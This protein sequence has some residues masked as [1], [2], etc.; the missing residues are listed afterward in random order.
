MEEVDIDSVLD[1]PN[2]ADKLSVQQMNRWDYVE[3]E[4]KFSVPSHLRGSNTAGKESLDTLRGR[5]R[6]VVEKGHNRKH[7]THP[8]KLSGSVDEI[9]HSKNTII[10]SPLENS[11]A[12]APLFG[13]STMERSRNSITE[14]YMDKGKAPCSKLPFKSSVFQENHAVIDLTEKKMYNQIPE[15]AFPQGGSKNHLAERRKECQVPRIGGSYFHN[16]ADNSAKSRNKCKGKEKIDG[17]EF[18]SVGLVMDHGKGVDPS[19]GSPV[20]MEKQLSASHHSFVSPRAVGRKRLVQNGCISPQNIVIK[21]KK[22]EFNKQS[23]NSFKVEQ[24]FGNLASYGKGKGVDYS[25]KPKEHE[26]NFINLSG[27]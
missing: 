22:E 4:S 1:I 24:N 3:E 15:R 25:H 5:G 11:Q 26:T 21:D 14:Q 17:I 16:S 2:T 19:H 27:R 18:R 13:K 6:L 7:Y 23:L 20:R 8:R 10:L 9:E 12:N